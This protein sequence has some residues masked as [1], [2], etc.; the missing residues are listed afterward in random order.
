MSETITE[1]DDIRHNGSKI[2]AALHKAFGVVAHLNEI[3]EE[4]DRELSRYSDARVKDFVPLL[5]ERNV[6]ARLRARESHEAH[7]AHEADSAH[8]AVAWGEQLLP[9]PE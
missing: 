6:R 3:S 9:K 2:A 7:S 4:V 5:V 1:L 8:A